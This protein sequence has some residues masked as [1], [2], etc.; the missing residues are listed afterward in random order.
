MAVRNHAVIA[1][2]LAV[3]LTACGSTSD[4]T[5]FSACEAPTGCHRADRVSGICQC[6][7]WEIVSVEPVPVKF[8]VVGV[9]YA[10]PGNAS[11]VVHGFASG[12]S[13]LP[14][15]ASDLGARWR[16]LVR[17]SD[18]T[19]TAALL[20]PSDVGAGLWDPL[21]KVTAAS[22]A[23]VQP[24]S[25]AVGYSPVI[26]LPS[27]EQDVFYVWINPAAAVTT[28]YAGGRSVSW[29]WRSECGYPGGCRSP[30]VYRLSAAL[31]SGTATTQNPDVQGILDSLSAADRATILAY[32][33]WFD[34]AGFNPTTRLT[35]VFY[36]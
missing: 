4:P 16:S 36:T 8:L 33:P 26:D 30:M 28:D 29:S 24:S 19:E 18:G 23:L 9:I 32:D 27:P 11:T 21:V 1:G 17:A 34:P 20:G 6:L 2:A 3:A 15:A 10:P 12:S 7:E 31:L 14:A 25:Q 5:T 35:H 13:Q 22:A